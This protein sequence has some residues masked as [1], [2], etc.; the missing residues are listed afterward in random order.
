MPDDSLGGDREGVFQRLIRRRY[1]PLHLFA[2]AFALLFA[3]A[4]FILGHS[5][6]KFARVIDRRLANGPFSDTLNIFTAPDTVATGDSL[7]EDE[8]IA[9]LR[10]GGYS[11]SPANPVGW[12]RRTP[13][14]VE[15]FPGNDWIGGES[16]LVEFQRGKI[17]RIVSL[18]D[19]TVRQRFELGPQLI[20]NLSGN[21]EKR[22]LVRY[23]QIPPSLVHAVV[24][25][26]D[27]RF[28]EHAGFDLFRMA[29]AAYVD[30]KE[31]RKLQ[32]ASTL[33]MQ[34]ARGLWLDPDKRW[35]RKIEELLITR[36]LESKLTK[37]QIFEDYANQVYLGRRGTFSILGFGEAAHVYFG[38]D[39]SQLT[40]AEAATLAGM[41][42]RPSYFNPFRDPEQTRE[43]RDVVLR[44]MRDNAYLNDA[45]FR[46]AAATPLGLNPE[47]AGNAECQ[48]FVELMNDELHSRLGES[49]DHAHSIYTTLDPDLQQAAQEAV[50]EG[51]RSI[52]RTIARGG[53]GPIPAGQPQVALIALDP[54]TG[55]IRALV[56][57]RNYAV[58]QLN[59]VEAMRQ[60]GSVFKPFVYAAALETAVERASR[61]FTP[62]STLDDSP[63][64]ISFANR[65]Y[66]PDNFHNEYM[67]RVTLTTALAHSLNSATVRLAQMVGYDRVL[68]VA[69][70]AGLNEAMK[71]TPALALGAYEA[72]P[73][74]IAEAYTA[75]ANRGVRV[76]P[77]AISMVRSADGKLLYQGMPDAR[78]AI[79]PRV[80]YL[81]DS[82]MQEVM[83]SGTAAGARARGF[84]LPAAGKT[85][86]SR[87]GW[88]AGFTSRLLCVVWVGF[89]DNRDLRIEG[90]RSALPIWTDFMKRA[91]ALDGYGGA[92]PFEEPPG[93]VSVRVCADSGD[94]ATPYC[95]RTR[96]AH[97]ID[98][99]QPVVYCKSHAARPVEPDSE[100]VTDID[101]LPPPPAPAGQPG[102][103]Q[104]TPAVL[105]GSP[106]AV[107]PSP[108]PATPPPDK[109]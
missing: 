93:V 32:G 87:D 57:G 19:N 107:L 49:A 100:S 42:Q 18:A 30:V 101:E 34:L 2:A 74:E 83:S 28:F 78:P 52:D 43:R 10:R 109:H 31:G 48:Y 102:P 90:S 60:P 12:Y 71:P 96:V 36:Y 76:T 1:K 33:T 13:G 62:S 70:A 77:T 95:P 14:S 105:Q 94:L 108:P 5:Y 8:L 22:R 44:L 51:M 38:K 37:Q 39:I 64:T 68:A 54:H 16:G 23:A 35:K 69:R 63:A 97:F 91:A 99:T 17:S 29:K 58:S 75:F 26:E 11:I 40:V 41:V 59:H 67:G 66:Q 4:V 73:L 98:G 47:Q 6:E 72:T 53:R 92:V 61:I 56:G 46:E 84:S 7:T 104:A 9:R 25:A 103:A 106:P 20:T 50:R 45:E 81:V 55:E 88:F 82:M 27:K 21:R 3:V 80:A 65:I 79:D 15:I 89:D 85:G 86:T 24:S